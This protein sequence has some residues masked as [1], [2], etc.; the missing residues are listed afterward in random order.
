[1]AYVVS[2]YRSETV[3]SRFRRGLVFHEP[4]VESEREEC[5][6]RRRRK[7]RGRNLVDE[8]KAPAAPASPLA[9]PELR[10]HSSRVSSEGKP[11]VIHQSDEVAETAFDAKQWNTAVGIGGGKDPLGPSTPGLT[12]PSTLRG[13]RGESYDKVVDNAFK[14]ALANKL[15]TFS[16]DVDT[17]SYSNIFATYSAAGQRPPANAV[18]IEEMINYFDYGYAEPKGEPSCSHPR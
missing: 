1:M 2:E 8:A 9:F 15:S 6:S 14:R 3:V 16:I 10:A 7:G 18:R 12:I 17:A 13:L 5:A 4:P 11:G